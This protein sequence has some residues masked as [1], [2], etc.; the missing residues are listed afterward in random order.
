[1]TELN[2]TGMVEVYNHQSLCPAHPRQ[3][4]ESPDVIEF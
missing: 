1:M 3:T 4:R 2:G